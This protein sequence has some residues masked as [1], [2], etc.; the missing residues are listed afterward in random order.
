MN[1]SKLKLR[2]RLTPYNSP[3]CSDTNEE[4]SVTT[5]TNHIPESE[6]RSL[7]KVV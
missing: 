4:Y 3:S 6:F 7:L 5:E 2:R 1:L